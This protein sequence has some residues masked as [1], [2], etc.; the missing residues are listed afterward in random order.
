MIRDP[1]NDLFGEHEMYIGPAL[2]LGEDFYG[3]VYL[4]GNVRKPTGMVLT[5]GDFGRAY[6]TNAWAT[7]FLVSLFQKY[8]VLF[9]GYSHND[10][11]MNYLTRGLPPTSTKRMAALD[12]DPDSPVSPRGGSGTTY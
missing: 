5:D 10:L 8:A 11:V 6:L 3:V 1:P 12:F 2:P 7:R 9:V 4:H